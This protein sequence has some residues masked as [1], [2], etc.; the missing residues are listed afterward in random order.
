MTESQ[1]ESDILDFLNAQPNIFAWKNVSSGFHDGQKFRKQSSP[2]AI[3]GT[4]DILG[5]FKSDGVLLAIEVKAPHGKISPDQQTFIAKL[6]RS[7]VV[8]GVVR[9]VDQARELLRASGRL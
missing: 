5:F 1:I 7:P 6:A 9:S 2:Y 8:V 3:R 4:S